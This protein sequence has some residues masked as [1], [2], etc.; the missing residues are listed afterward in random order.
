MTSLFTRLAARTLAPTPGLRPVAPARHGP[1]PADDG[2][3][4]EDLLVPAQA[5]SEDAPAPTTRPAEGTPA[6]PRRAP[7]RRPEE[8]QGPPPP[9]PGT[10]DR[11]LRNRSER[12]V[13]DVD[14]TRRTE[15]SGPPEA[16]HPTPG[17]WRRSEPAGEPPPPR[18]LRPSLEAEPVRRLRPALPAPQETAPARTRRPEAWAGPPL[19]EPPPRQAPVVPEAPAG[20]P[21]PAA[22]HGHARPQREETTVLVSIGR[23]EIRGAEQRP[24]PS[25]PVP[26][27]EAP[28]LNLGDYLERRRGGTS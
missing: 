11:S 18:R 27:S 19:L 1:M 10:E 13:R 3:R 8:A 28:M 4:E 17:P 5:S 21:A 22:R 24:A 6:V 25:T 15:R 23:I 16:E 20:T 12:S 14:R 26:W 7:L 2:G 9:W